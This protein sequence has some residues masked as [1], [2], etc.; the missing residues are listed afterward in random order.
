MNRSRR[1]AADRTGRPTFDRAVP[2]IFDRLVVLLVVQAHAYHTA[3]VVVSW[4]DY[5][6][7]LMNLVL[8]VAS[9][10]IPI[11][12][13]VSARRS[14]G[15]LSGG[16]FLASGLAL[17]GVAGLQVVSV[18]PAARG[19]PAV[20]CWGA[21]G[22]TWL[23]FAAFRPAREALAFAATHS[24]IAVIA[25]TPS[26]GQGGVDL[27]RILADVVGC[28]SPALVAAQ[29]IGLHVRSR[30]LRDEAAAGSLAAEAEAQAEQAIEQDSVL[31]LEELRVAAI[32]LLYDIVD[33]VRSPTD[34]VVAE[35]SRVL[36]EQLR[37]ELVEARTGRWLLDP[38]PRRSADSNEEGGSTTPVPTQSPRGPSTCAIGRRRP[39]PG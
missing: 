24:A 35:R 8:F 4:A 3:M 21:I 13:A 16:L 26:I 11:G 12:C 33:G 14:G 34:E 30:Q 7:P 38:P 20:W 39:G 28:V 29:Y 36:A 5:R 19:G 23:A 32:P 27:F 37:H 2:P 22:V 1:A 18:Y 10:G 6:Y 25:M 9:F 17:L 31:R 15:V